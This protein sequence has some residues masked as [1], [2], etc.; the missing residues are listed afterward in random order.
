MDIDSAF[1]L[2]RG[3]TVPWSVGWPPPSGNKILS[4]N[5]TSHVVEEAR[6]P[7]VW[8]FVG[9]VDLFVFVLPFCFGASGGVYSLQDITSVS[10]VCK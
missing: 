1:S 6:L 3:V 9:S 10:K 2:L 8:N 7:F 4:A 5:S